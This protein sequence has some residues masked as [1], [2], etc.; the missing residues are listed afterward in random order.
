M[1]VTPTLELYNKIMH[2]M[3]QGEISDL[4][5]EVQCA[6]INDIITDDKDIMILNMAMQIKSNYF[7]MKDLLFDGMGKS[8]TIIIMD[9][10][11]EEFDPE[12]IQLDLFKQEEFD[13]LQEKGVLFIK[14]FD[15]KE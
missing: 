7:L 13:E 14:D 10:N 8:S 1:K 3:T 12:Q 15:K 5:M 9:G 6:V 2:S 11:E 4:E